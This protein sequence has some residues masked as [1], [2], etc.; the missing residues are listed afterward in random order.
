MKVYLLFPLISIL[1]LANCQQK[2]NQDDI[3]YTKELK[4]QKQINLPIDENTYFVSKSIFQFEENG[5]EY[6]FF[7]NIEKRLYDF[8]L[9][10]LENQKVIK[11]IPIEREGP[12]GL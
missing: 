3:T 1:I 11:R 12:N 4:K 7:K 8:I 5:R 10:D 2:E 9:F 6:L